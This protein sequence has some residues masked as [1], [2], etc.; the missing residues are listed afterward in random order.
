MDA[1]GQIL[2][3]VLIQVVM[4]RPVSLSRIPH[5]GG[6]SKAKWEPFVTSVFGRQALIP[7]ANMEFIY[8]ELSCTERSSRCNL[9]EVMY[10][11][12][13]YGNLK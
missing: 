8:L 7:Q 4:Y 10:N 12:L 2:R 11:T 3:K 6:E 5:V 13:N 9:F 1:S